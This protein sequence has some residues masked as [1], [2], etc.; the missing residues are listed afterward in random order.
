[1]L[2]QHVVEGPEY[3]LSLSARISSPAPSASLP[4][5]PSQPFVSSE[6]TRFAVEFFRFNEIEMAS[7]GGM[8]ADHLMGAL[9][10]HLNLEVL[11][12]LLE[13]F[14]AQDTQ[15]PAEYLAPIVEVR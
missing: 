9:T 15:G 6:T 12:V 8:F 11:T 4:T 1:M 7:V 13:F 2:A 10:D 3:S 5:P 14:A